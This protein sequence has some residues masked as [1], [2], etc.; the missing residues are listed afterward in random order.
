MF[1]GARSLSRN[2]EAWKL[3]WDPPHLRSFHSSVRHI[4]NLSFPVRSVTALGISGCV[5]NIREKRRCGVNISSA[6]AAALR[7]RSGRGC[8]QPG[9]LGESLQLGLSLDCCFGWVGTVFCKAVRLVRCA[10]EE[11]R[12]SVCAGHASSSVSSSGITSASVRRTH[13]LQAQCYFPQHT[14]VFELH[15][16]TGKDRGGVLHPHE[17]KPCPA[18][19]SASHSGSGLC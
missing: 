15:T 16:R 5:W 12:N 10:R 1:D 11:R 19:W 9:T 2:G 18:S 14:V 3:L 17:S 13:C 6:P 4:G 7:Q 8:Q